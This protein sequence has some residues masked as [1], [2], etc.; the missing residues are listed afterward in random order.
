MT[1]ISR[2]LELPFSAAQ[3]YALVND[4]SRYPEFVPYCV[5]TQIYHADATSMRASLAIEWH[6]VHAQV[7]TENKLI[8]NQSIGLNLATTG[9]AHGVIKHLSGQW[10]FIDRGP[11]AS[12]VRLL[13]ELE[14]KNRWMG[15]LFK[16]IAEQIVNRLTD[17]FCTRAK[18][19]YG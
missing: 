8:E 16:G 15:V 2:Q 11:Q 4:V 19:I 12:G 6:G 13:I 1:T 9:L 18:A 14:F 3:M 10:Q 5:G 7:M 17:A